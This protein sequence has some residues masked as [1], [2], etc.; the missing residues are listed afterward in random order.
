MAHLGEDTGMW[1]DEDGFFTTSSGCP[2]DGRTR[3]KVRSMVGLLPLCAATAFDGEVDRVSSPSSAMRF[4][5]FSTRD[6]RSLTPL[7][8]DPR[9]PGVAGRRASPASLDETKLRRVLAKMLD[10]DE[11]L[12]PYGL[13]S[14]SRST[15]PT[16]L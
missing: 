2:T 6:R 10:E 1:D 15:T 4:G 8:H 13:R 12:G 7:I 9:Q 3:L 14:L 5:W 11:F 16:I